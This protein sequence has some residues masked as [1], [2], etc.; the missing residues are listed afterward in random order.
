[1]C[2][3]AFGGAVRVRPL[4]IPPLRQLPHPHTI[5]TVPSQFLPCLYQ[6]NNVSV[7]NRLQLLERATSGSIIQSIIDI[8]N[9]RTR[10][11]SLSTLRIL[12][13]LC[14]YVVSRIHLLSIV[15]SSLRQNAVMSDAATSTCW[16]SRL[17]FPLSS[18]LLC[19]R[20]LFVGKILS[21]TRSPVKPTVRTSSTTL[22]FSPR[23]P[24]ASPIH[25]STL[26]A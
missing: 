2:R 13:P 18:L 25:T 26:D 16:H 17:L 4:T 1:M 22:D 19:Q 23:S 20:F 7:N 21:A 3:S 15:T 8:I 14:P 6:R 10:A 11:P 5:A 24:F 9:E 12:Q